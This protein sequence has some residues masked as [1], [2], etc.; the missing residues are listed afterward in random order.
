MASPLSPGVPLPTCV[1]AGTVTFL[2]SHFKAIKNRTVQLLNVQG[3]LEKGCVP[4][5]YAA[6]SS[7]RPFS[8]DVHGNNLQQN[9]D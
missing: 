2:A 1:L 9:L 4:C 7:G 5:P 6:F 8:S 3:E